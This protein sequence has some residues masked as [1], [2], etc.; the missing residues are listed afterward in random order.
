MVHTHFLSKGEL[1]NLKHF[2][3]IIN[4]HIKLFYEL[5]KIIGPVCKPVRR[6]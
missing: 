6:I 4:I 1:V 3:E 2:T 5:Q